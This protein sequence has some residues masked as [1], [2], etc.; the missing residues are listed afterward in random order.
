MSKLI[1]T[2]NYARGDVN[3]DEQVNLLDA[4]FLI[5]YVFVGGPAPQPLSLADVNCSGSINIADVVLLINYIFRDGPAPC[6][7]L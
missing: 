7:G 1:W 5:N 3:T 2:P 4:V 6:A